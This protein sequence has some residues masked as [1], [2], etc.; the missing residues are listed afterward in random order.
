MK[1]A[2]A[3]RASNIAKSWILITG[4]AAIVIA[5]GYVLA[6]MYG[7]SSILLFAVAFS[8]ITTG[9]SYFFSDRIALAASRAK[10]VTQD[11][12]PEL[13]AT[14]QRLSAVAGIPM[15]R[16]YLTDERQINAFATGRNPAHAA[17]AVTR[18]ALEKLTPAELEGVLA[19]ELSHVINRDILISSIAVVLAGVIAMA[20]Q[21]LGSSMLFGG[22]SDREERNPFSMILSIALILLAPLGA[23]IMQLAISRRR[24]SLADVSGS[25][26]TGKPG[27]LANA[28][29]KIGADAAPLRAANDATAHLWISNP[30]KGKEALGFIH[31]LFMTHPPVEDRVA[32]LRAMQ[33]GQ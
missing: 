25:L 18:G 22:N 10:P 28:L 9:I 11:Q 33:S 19:H 26:L 5:F 27:D 7:N 6:Q 12:Q 23:T 16:L 32:A 31:R 17:V 15:P 2:F 21:Y 13:Y 20:S 29:T 1:N 14:V 30:F 8:F 4:F 24:E 3:Q